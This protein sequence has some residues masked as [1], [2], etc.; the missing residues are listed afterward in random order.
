M[1]KYK[2]NGK[3]SGSGSGNENRNGNGNGNWVEDQVRRRLADRLRSAGVSEREVAVEI[4]YMLPKE[5]VR[6]YEELYLSAL[7]MG[8][9]VGQGAAGGKVGGVG[10]LGDEDEKKKAERAV[11]KDPRNRDVDGKRRGDMGLK[12]RV[13]RGVSSKPGGRPGLD[14]GR[15]TGAD[16]IRDED[17]LEVKARVDRKLKK[18]I[19]EVE[20]R[21]A[22]EKA[23]GE[24]HG[25][26]GGEFEVLDNGREACRN[27]RKLMASDYVRCPYCIS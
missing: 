1:G 25:S 23:R 18:V 4:L 12:T 19:E 3:G 2:G 26:M 13:S 5:F 21:M 11:R 16:W 10:N 15:G 27:C 22:R 9:S 20:R 6:A 8:D 14:P 7:N 17:A 24:S